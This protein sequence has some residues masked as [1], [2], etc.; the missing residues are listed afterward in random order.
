MRKF[1]WKNLP[2]ILHP[3]SPIAA[4]LLAAALPLYA[5]PPDGY[6][7]IRAAAG[8]ST[9]VITTTRR[10]AGAID[11]FQ[12]NG[13]EFID[14]ADHGRQ[15]QSA[16]S[17]DLTPQAG[18][19]TFNPTEAGSRDDGAGANTTSRLIAITADGHHLRTHT[20]MAFWLAPGELSEGQTA[21]NTNR[22]SDYFLTKDVTIGYGRWPQALDYQVTFTLPSGANHHFAQFE[23]LTG[24]MPPDFSRFWEFNPT[25][26]RVQP[27]S[28][29]PGEINDPVV[30]ATP[31]GHY[32]MGIF[33][34]P[35][36]Q[37]NT[38]GPTYGRWR[39]DSAKVVKWNCVFRVQNPEGI[40]NGDYPYRLRVAFGTLEQVEAMLRDWCPPA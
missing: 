8:S 16:C 1:L 30:L 25:V 22:V 28:D 9:V 7:Q 18:A 37:P 11:S 27:L 24:Y 26:G 12:W 5:E 21:R 31:D 19:E 33:S 15:L 20:Q 3:R 35:Q 10:L 14:S 29:G 4:L 36:T 17:F 32:A 2:P 34:P 6:A 40:R 23:A 38:T 13:H 39:F